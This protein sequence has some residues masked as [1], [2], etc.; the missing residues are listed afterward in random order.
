MLFLRILACFI[1]QSRGVKTISTYFSVWL[2]TVTHFNTPKIEMSL[3]AL[4]VIENGFLLPM[5]KYWIWISKNEGIPETTSWKGADYCSIQ[6]CV[7][8]CH[9]VSVRKI[10]TSLLDKC[11]KFI[12]SQKFWKLT[13]KGLIKC[14]LQGVYQ[15]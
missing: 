14:M 1:F 3:K 9:L 13:N 15:L 5:W 2:W 8:P 4:L 7:W 6:N 10:T 11:K 12:I